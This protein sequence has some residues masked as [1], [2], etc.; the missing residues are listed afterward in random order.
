M[1]MH[2]IIS[3]GWSIDIL[4]RELALFYGA[5]IRGEDPLQQAS[6]LPIQYRDFAVWQKQEAQ[7]AEQQRQL[8]Y[9]KQQL[10]GSQP[11][12]FLCD[13]PRPAV[14]SGKALFHSLAIEG[15]LYRDLQ[16]FCKAYQAT[17]FAVLFAAFRAT[18]YRL[19]CADD[20]TIGTPIATDRN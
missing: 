9:W 13:K 17:P 10:E 3:D 1:V 19:T 11:A 18:H 6:P 4:Q 14:S 16:Q 8:E 2:H 5:F 7:L 12:E 15:A 20:A